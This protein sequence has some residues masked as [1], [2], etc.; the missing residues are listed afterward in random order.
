M[1]KQKLEAFDLRFISLL[2]RYHLWIARIA[3]FIVFFWF[4]ILKVLGF[5]PASP[6]AAALTERT[7]GLQYFGG[8]F[9]AL[10]VVECLIGVLFL[11]PK[12]IRI[13]LPLLIIHMILVCSPLLLL[14]DLVW[15][16]PFVP[17]LEGQYI[18]KNAVIV[19]LAI[20]IASATQPLKRNT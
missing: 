19:A 16:A 13:V 17:T 10:S 1:T 12:A 14:P 6:L 4:G 3:L 18:I 20:A 5:S 11:F 15:S 2:R 7:I 8:M 9:L